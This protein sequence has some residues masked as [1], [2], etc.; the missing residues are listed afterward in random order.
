MMGVGGEGKKRLLTCLSL[1][2]KPAPLRGTTIQALHL[3]HTS[4]PTTIHPPMTRWQKRSRRTSGPGPRPSRSALGPAPEEPE[5][6][7]GESNDGDRSD[8]DED[9]QPVKEGELEGDSMELEVEEEPCVQ[10]E[11]DG[12]VAFDVSSLAYFDFLHSCDY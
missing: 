8:M 9:E 2:D 11:E 10:R 6:A 3:L 12:L 5:I 1:G 7:E 4:L